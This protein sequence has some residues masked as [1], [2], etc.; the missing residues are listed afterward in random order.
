M[1]LF[2]ASYKHFQ[3]ISLQTYQ[4]IVRFQIFFQPVYSCSGV[5]RKNSLKMEGFFN[6]F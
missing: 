5:S 4:A 6:I 3:N 2:S 1:H